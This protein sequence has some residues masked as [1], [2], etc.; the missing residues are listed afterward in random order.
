MSGP[1]EA[2]TLPAAVTQINKVTTPAPEGT[3]RNDMLRLDY[4]GDGSDDHVV[5]L[6]RT[7][8]M[9]TKAATLKTDLTNFV[10]VEKPSFEETVFS[11]LKK[12]DN[13]IDNCND[14]LN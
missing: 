7:Q 8:S 10:S 4:D 9:T 6:S 12:L 5:E 2:S 14:M 1:V 3:P 13:K 11:M